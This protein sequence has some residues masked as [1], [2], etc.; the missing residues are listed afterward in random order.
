[1]SEKRRLEET[2][3]KRPR[4]VYLIVVSAIVLALANRLDWIIHALLRR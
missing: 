1:V 3:A 4:F 2:P